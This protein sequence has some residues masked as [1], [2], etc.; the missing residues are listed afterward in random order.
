M[1][2]LRLCNDFSKPF[3]QITEVLIEMTFNVRG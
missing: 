2:Y 1:S 3:L